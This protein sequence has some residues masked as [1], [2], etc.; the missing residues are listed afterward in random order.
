MPRNDVLGVGL[1]RL[2]G[3]LDYL[4]SVFV[5]K[6]LFK[7]APKPTHKA[8]YNHVQASYG[9]SFNRHR[10]EVLFLLLQV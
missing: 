9:C 6:A 8:V 7:G 10:T 4:F 3:S 2:E 5:R 1:F